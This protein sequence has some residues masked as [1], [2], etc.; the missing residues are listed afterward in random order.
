[1]SPDLGYDVVAIYTMKSFI[2]VSGVF[3]RAQKQK[4]FPFSDREKKTISSLVLFLSVPRVSCFIF[5]PLILLER[6]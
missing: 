4:G 1:M 3:G 2:G 5:K 6:N